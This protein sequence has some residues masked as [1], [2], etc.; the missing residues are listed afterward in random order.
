[1]I[2]SKKTRYAIVALTDWQGN[3]VKAPYRLRKLLKMK[4]F[5][6]V[7]L[8]TYYSSSENWEFLEVNLENPE[9]TFF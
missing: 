7:F 4:K 5:H 1:M 9:V 8:R 3:T 6:R 2:L